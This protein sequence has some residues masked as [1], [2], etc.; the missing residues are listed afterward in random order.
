MIVRIKA[1]ES[2]FDYVNIV[3][4]GYRTGV[5]GIT[6]RRAIELVSLRERVGSAGECVEE[7]VGGGVGE[8]WGKR[9][10]TRDW[11]ICRRS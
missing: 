7:G 10:C 9:G 1:N 2:G 11:I 5:V 8:E 4:G 6:M 3:R